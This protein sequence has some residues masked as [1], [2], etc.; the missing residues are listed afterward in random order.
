MSDEDDA[1]ERKE[2]HARER[3]LSADAREERDRDPEL[4][5]VHR[6]DDETRVDERRRL[7]HVVEDAREH[8]A[9]ALR[10]EVREAQRLDVIEQLRGGCLV[11]TPCPRCTLK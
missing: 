1:V 6:S 8:G 11:T 4:R 3:Q 2:R 9:G 7:V 10:R 5:Q